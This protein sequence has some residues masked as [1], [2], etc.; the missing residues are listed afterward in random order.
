MADPLLQV[1]DVR[2]NFGGVRALRGVSLAVGEGETVGLIGPNG[3]GKSTLINVTAGYYRADAGTLLFRGVDITG[4]APHRRAAMGLA[5]TYQHPRPFGSMSAQ[6]NVAVGALFGAGDG[7]RAPADAQGAA[8]RWLHL[9][10]MDRAAPHPVHRLT[11]QE[12]RLLELARALASHPR[13]ILADEV[14]AGLTPAEIERV[15]DAIRTI[16]AMGV[17]LLVVE[18]NVKAVRT[19]ADRIVV[20]HEGT[21]LA[22]GA[23]EDVLRDERVRAAYLGSHGGHA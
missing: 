18:H 21:V 2:K 11:L 20:L 15:L 7:G 8:Q 9:L 3:S 6:D 1:R 19:L 16:R 10:G 23:P 14:L 22:E 12:R 17:A 4:L 13:I 5:R